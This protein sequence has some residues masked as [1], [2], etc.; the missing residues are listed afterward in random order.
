MSVIY[1]KGAYY[2]GTTQNKTT[3]TS[4]QYTSAF[5]TY[6]TIVRVAT[7]NDTYVRPITTTSTTATTSSMIIPGGGVEFLAVDGGQRVAFLQV[8]SGGWISITELA[9]TVAE[10]SGN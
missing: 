10:T 5:G 7:Q 9:N 8:S 4:S 1:R 2:P 6:T 3:T